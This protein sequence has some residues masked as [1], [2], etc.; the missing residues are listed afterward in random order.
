MSMGIE[1]MAFTEF[2]LENMQEIVSNQID[3]AG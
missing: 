2:G 3:R 1:T